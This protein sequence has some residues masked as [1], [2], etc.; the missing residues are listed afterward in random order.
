MNRR[1]G[2]QFYAWTPAAA[3]GLLVILACPLLGQE[4]ILLNTVEEPWR[5]VS[6]QLLL[7][8]QG[9]SSGLMDNRS[10]ARTRGALSDF[11]VARGLPDELAAWQA[12]K[13]DNVPVFGSYVISESDLA[14]LGRAPSDWEQASRE[15]A[16]AFESLPEMLSE[17]F[18]ISEPF[19][20]AINPEVE[21]NAA[22]AGVR[23]VVLNWREPE[24][25]RDVSRVEIDAARFRL[26]VFDTGDTVRLSFPCSVARDRS[27]IPE[28]ELKMAVFAPNPDYTF[29]PANYPESARARAIGRSLILPPGP[30][31][32][33]G[34][35]WIG[36]NRPG[37]GIHG[38]PH[39]ESIGSMES[40]GCFRLMNR[41]VLTLSRC[42]RSG[43]PVLIKTGDAPA[44][45]V[46]P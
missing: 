35:Y 46:S 20:R 21:W 15:P 32:P 34:V 43:L 29:N 7:A 39:P 13:K 45:A 19:L 10:G 42:V 27:R 23:V 9:F 22:T 3:L 5:V 30:N 41:D 40:H 6:V 25:L 37:F 17:T 18:V 4:P 8:R 12:L 2:L 33:V 26:R 31:N 11:M 16:L 24:P 38:T 44:G 36:L 1:A 14:S 28:G